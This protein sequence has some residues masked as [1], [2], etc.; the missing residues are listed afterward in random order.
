MKKILKSTGLFLL[1]LRIPVSVGA[2]IG[3]RAHFE[4]KDLERACLQAYDMMC[5]QVHAC[6]KS[7]VADCDARVRELQMCS[8]VQLPHIDIIQR[9]TQQ[10]RHIEC[11]HDLPASCM[12]LME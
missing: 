7:S 11:E 6:T 5:V 2:L 9:C 4:S 12:L 10:L 3:V 1:L 8:T